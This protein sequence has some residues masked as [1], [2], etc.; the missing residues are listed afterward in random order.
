MSEGFSKRVSEMTEAWQPFKKSLG[1]GFE[2]IYTTMQGVADK[3]RG[4]TIPAINEL[5]SA[6]SKVATEIR[7][8]VEAGSLSVK[9]ETQQSRGFNAIPEQYKRMAGFQAHAAGGIFSTPHLGIVAEAGREAVIPLQDKNRGIPLLMT[10]A[11]EL[12]VF[13][14]I[15][16]LAS[17]LDIATPLED[18]VKGIPLW[19]AAEPEQNILAP[20]NTT[21]TTNNNSENNSRS[22]TLSPSFNIT[23]NG[24]ERG[25]EQRFRQ[26]VE[27]VLGNLRNDME[28]LSF[29]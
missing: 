16:N 15:P 10:A 29:A 9:V 4:V 12:G 7:S 5:T 27:E 18:K 21:N 3:I 17:I 6:L 23:V 25:I 11:K 2:Q 22:I 26:I 28:R 8:I 1:E 14:K 20:Q 13:S 24:G 19:K